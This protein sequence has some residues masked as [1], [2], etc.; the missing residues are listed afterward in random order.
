AFGGRRAALGRR[1]RLGL[2]PARGSTRGARHGR[3][4]V[5]RAAPVVVLIVDYPTFVIGFP[6]NDYVRSRHS[7]TGCLNLD[8]LVSSFGN[9]CR[10]SVVVCGRQTDRVKRTML[11]RKQKFGS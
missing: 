8:M 7:T 2:T 6:P 5:R 3:G 10:L 4:L 11:T 1:R 9:S